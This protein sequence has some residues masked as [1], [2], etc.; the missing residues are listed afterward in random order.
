[1]RQFFVPKTGSGKRD[2]ILSSSEADTRNQLLSQQYTQEDQKAAEQKQQLFAQQTEAKVREQEQRVEEARIRDEQRRNT[3]AVDERKREEANAKVKA[4]FLSQKATKD[5]ADKLAADTAAAQKKHDDSVNYWKS[6]VQPGGQ[7]ISE[8]WALRNGVREPTGPVHP[9]RAS[10]KVL[11]ALQKLQADTTGIVDTDAELEARN[12]A[13]QEANTASDNARADE[14][15]KRAEQALK[16]AEQKRQEKIKQDRK[17]EVYK[18]RDDIAS[19][20]SD[21]QH[22]QALIVHYAEEAQKERQSAGAYDYVYDKKT[23]TTTEVKD[24]KKASREEGL[25]NKQ[26]EA[27]AKKD[28]ALSKID[29][30]KKVH[31]DRT[32]KSSVSQIVSADKHPENNVLLDSENDTPL[33]RAHKGEQLDN[34][35]RQAVEKGHQFSTAE[36]QKLK[37]YIDYLE[38]N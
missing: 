11:D 34:W 22:Q 18:I 7:D 6:Q 28:A 1:M 5:K 21:V 33:D 13:A 12:K 17:Q 38:D 29:Y 23:K 14:S 35:V 26:A 10:H 25:R 27:Q 8:G 31:D 19:T 37:Q 15:Q 36:I 24:E 4:W 16:D 30:L 32:G 2:L 20:Q 9:P 3:M